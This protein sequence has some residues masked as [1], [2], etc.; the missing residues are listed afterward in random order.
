MPKVMTPQVTPSSK[1]SLYDEKGTMRALR[2]AEKCKNS[3]TK[4]VRPAVHGI[5]AVTVKVIVAGK[6]I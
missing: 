6:F 2:R 3:V 1:S 4:I 5:A